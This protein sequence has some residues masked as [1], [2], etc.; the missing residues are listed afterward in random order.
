MRLIVRVPLV[1][2]C[3]IGL[4]FCVLTSAITWPYVTRLRDVVSVSAHSDRFVC[5]RMDR[6]YLLCVHAV[7]IQHAGP[8]DVSV[9]SVGPVVIRSVGAVC[10]G[11]KPQARGLAWIRI[12]HDRIDNHNL[13]FVIDRAAGYRRRDPP[14]AK[15]TL[16]RSQV[17]AKGSDC[18]GR[19]LAG[20]ASV[21]DTVLHRGKGLWV[22]ASRRRG[23]R[24]F[25][26]HNTLARERRA[27]PA[28]ARLG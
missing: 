17:L 23:P 21:H 7:P 12:L 27:Q 18:I 5:D 2:E 14:D 20:A 22:Q 9:L 19:R 6:R 15:K 13:V 4:A 3:L 1:R 8:I 26:L 11:T 10:A 16:A 24:T 28:L 25:G